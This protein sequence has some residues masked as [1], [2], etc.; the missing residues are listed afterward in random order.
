[1]KNSCKLLFLF[2]LLLSFK[3]VQLQEYLKM[4]DAET[5]SVDGIRTNA[6]SCFFNRDRGK[7]SGYVQYKRWEY[8][9]MRLVNAEG[10]LSTA[11]QNI[12]EWD[13]FVCGYRRWNF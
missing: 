11:D 1:M 2:P 4:I 10:Y 12:A 6:E 5:Y 7:G 3:G 9:A 13:H 8:N